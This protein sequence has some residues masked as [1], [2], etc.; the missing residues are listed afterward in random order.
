[1]LALCEAEARRADG[2]SDG[3]DW[4]IVAERWEALHRLHPVAYARFRQAEAVLGSHGSRDVAASLLGQAH[5]VATELGAN[6]LRIEIEG[7]A[8]H[9]RIDV[10]RTSVESDQTNVATADGFAVFGLTERESEVIGLV[11]AGWSNQQIADTLFITRK[12]ASVHVSNIMGKFGVRNRV[13][14]AAIAHR[15]GMAIQEP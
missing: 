2:P 12:T 7:L 1:M 9:A 4:A 15:L 8:R 3:S 11:A 13:E 5:G 6:Q 14:A 10:H